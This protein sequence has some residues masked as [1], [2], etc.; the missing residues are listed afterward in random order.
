MA[1]LGAISES[2]RQPME[3]SLQIPKSLS[4][5]PRMANGSRL[6]AKIGNDMKHSRY[7]SER[8]SRKAQMDV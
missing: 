6:N 5:A 7:V 3:K 1:S 4:M 2:H 8:L